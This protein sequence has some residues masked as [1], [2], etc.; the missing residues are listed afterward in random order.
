MINFYL[1]RGIYKNGL[2]KVDVE[3]TPEQVVEASE[4]VQEFEGQ[5]R[6]NL[7]IDEKTN[8]IDEQDDGNR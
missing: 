2:D 7:T 4:Q 5:V 6:Q 1:K 8:E 3:L